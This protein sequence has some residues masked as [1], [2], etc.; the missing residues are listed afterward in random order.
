MKTSQTYKIV[1][2]T[3]LALLA[4]LNVNAQNRWSNRPYW[5]TH[6]LL[7]SSFFLSDLGG[8]DYFGSNDPSDID[9]NQTRYAFGSGIQFTWPTG[10]S[11]GLDAFYTRLS[12]DDAETNW[13]RKYRKLKVRTDVIE[14]ALKLEYTIPE[15]AGSLRGFYI[16]A[17]VGLFYYQPMNEINGVWYSLRELGT[18]GQ[19]VDPNQEVYSTFSPVIPFG[20][21]KKFFLNNGMM[22]ALDISLRKTYTDYLDDVS[23][24]YFDADAIRQSAGEAAAILSNPAAVDLISGRSMGTPG[25]RRGNPENFDN[26]FLFGFKLIIPLGNGLGRNSNRNCSFNN[27]WIS[28]NGSLPKISKRGKKRKVR[29]FR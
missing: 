4:F 14:A 7:S 10:L 8:K 6:I 29:L 9:F 22:F 12:A 19:L 5:S 16:N 21:G 26:Y 3:I 28:G 23:G 15:N 17:G 13:D 20:I 11:V 18:E 25:S 27:S 24:S 1:L 2:F